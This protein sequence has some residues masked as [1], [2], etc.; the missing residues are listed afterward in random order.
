MAKVISSLQHPLVKHLVKLRHNHDYR[1]EKNAV[2]VEG[3]K[4]VTEVCSHHRATCIIATEERLIPSYL[5]CDEQ[6]IISESIAKKISGLPFNE[7]IFAELAM[8]QSIPIKKVKWLLACDGVSDPGNLGTLLRTALALG[9]EAFFI[10]DNCCDP[11]NDKALRAAKGATFR[12]PLAFGTWKELQKISSSNQLTPFVA[13]MN[14]V[15]VRQANA[16]EG[17]LLVLNNEAHGISQIANEYC[18]K[19]SIPMSGQ[20]E[21]LNVGVAGGILMF[22]L[23]QGL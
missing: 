21:S 9:W 4:L 22:A 8:P 15:S 5:T 1:W 20:M 16:T 12:M 10:L 2:L 14:G 19:I 17:I 7:G 18:R 6:I 13:D 23:R 3:I 11:F